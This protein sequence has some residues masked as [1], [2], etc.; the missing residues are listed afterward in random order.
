MV[1]TIGLICCTAL[2]PHVGHKYL[3]DF[4]SYFCDTVH[5]IVSTRSFEPRLT[6]DRANIL[7]KMYSE[8]NVCVHE[9]LDDTAP[10]NDDGSKEFW[11]YWTD[12]VKSFGIK[13]VDYVL[14]SEAYGQ[15]F[16]DALGCEF[17]PVDIDRD[18][19]PISGTE[20]RSDLAHNFK[21]IIP[22]FQKVLHKKICITG[23]ESAGKTTMSKW[24]AQR[25]KGQWVHEYAR[26]YLEFVGTEL[27]ETKMFNIV[28]GQYAAMMAAPKTLFT[29]LDTD[30]SAT[31]MY[32]DIGKFEKPKILLDK[33]EETCNGIFY[34]V[35][36][37]KIPFEADPLRYGGDV[38]ESNTEDWIKFY[39]D[40]N[41]PYY[42]V[43]ETDIFKQRKEILKAVYG[44]YEDLREIEEFVRD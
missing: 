17:I 44:Y 4:A 18:I 5:V 32:Y 16:A 19:V 10:Q 43:K 6:L 37:D 33:F 14:A 40:R 3:I 30:I 9:H 29:V 41:L 11:D 39:E 2:V 22:E 23:T 28:L 1:K 42:A 20:V 36:N 31:I 38:R 7:R 21:Y 8:T 12:T 25:L 15:K 27:T 13:E 35:M 24:L 26:T 34:I